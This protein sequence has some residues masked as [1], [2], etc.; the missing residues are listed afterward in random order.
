MNAVEI[1][2]GKTYILARRDLPDS[3]IRW[4]DDKGHG[5]EPEA[6]QQMLD[7]VEFYRAGKEDRTEVVNHVTYV[8]HYGRYSLHFWAEEWSVDHVAY[9]KFRESVDFAVMQQLK[10]LALE[11]E[12][13][14]QDS[15][16][17]LKR[18]NELDHQIALIERVDDLAVR[19]LREGHTLERH[20][21]PDGSGFIL[22]DG[23]VVN[24]ETEAQLNDLNRHPYLKG[25]NVDMFTA[26]YTLKT[27]DEIHPVAGDSA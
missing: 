26:R 20:S 11:R 18:I 7:A 25:F 5:F 6:A 3:S 15:R 12:R 10:A 4:I 19:L 17:L 14:Y 22:V 2:P 21:Y 23:E 13:V 27:G 24:E 1:V 8:H 9:A 16:A